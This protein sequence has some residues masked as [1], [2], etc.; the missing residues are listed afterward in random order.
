MSRPMFVVNIVLI[1]LNLIVVVLYYAKRPPKM[2]EKMPMTIASIL[3]LVEGSGLAVKTTDAK[4]RAEWHI[5]YG[6]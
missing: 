6:R 5:G 2:L 3:K 1:A 4:T